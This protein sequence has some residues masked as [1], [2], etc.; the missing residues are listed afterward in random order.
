MIS[1]GLY[2]QARE[3]ARKNLGVFAE[4]A[5]RGYRIVGTS[6]S[7]THTFKAEYE[8]MLDLHD[9]DAKAVSGA[10]WDIMEFLLDLHEAGRLDTGFGRIDEDLPYHA[11]CQLRSHGIGLP[12]LDLFELVPGLRARDMDHDCCGIAGTYGLKREKYE[13]AMKVGADLFEAIERSDA[14]ETACDSETC[15]WQIAAATGRPS[16]HPVE[17]LARAYEIADREGREGAPAPH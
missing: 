16:R 7:C 9:D 2:G 17:F 8:E 12:A 3:Q 13:T 10:T 5:R 4:Y 14:T 1:N 6:T 11:P 15:R